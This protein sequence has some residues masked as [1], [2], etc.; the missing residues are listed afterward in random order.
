MLTLD[1]EASATPEGFGAS[2]K[3]ALPV[4]GAVPILEGLRKA[5]ICGQG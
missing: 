3:I 5:S 4:P 1:R 2:G